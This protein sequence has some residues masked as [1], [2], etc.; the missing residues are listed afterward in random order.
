[1][2]MFMYVEASAITAPISLP[3]LL[4][5]RTVALTRHA[6]GQVSRHSSILLRALALT[7]PVLDR[8]D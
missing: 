8:N 2:N 1:M 5:R 7:E 4:E 6:D 3:A